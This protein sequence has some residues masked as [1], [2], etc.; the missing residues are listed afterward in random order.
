MSIRPCSAV[1]R[2]IIG[3]QERARELLYDHLVDTDYEFLDEHA[4]ILRYAAVFVCF[5]GADIAGYI[6][7]YQLEEDE[8][9]WVVH[10]SIVPRFRKRFFSRT[11]INTLFPACYAM[12]C[13]AVLAENES[14]EILERIGGEAQPDGSVILNLPFIWR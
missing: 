12:G 8:Y 9:T 4:D 2:P 11:M 3:D 5:S 6:W 7:F 10:I 1:V 14:S 13:N